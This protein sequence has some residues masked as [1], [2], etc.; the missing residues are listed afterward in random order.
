M[1]N[2]TYICGRNESSNLTSLSKNPKEKLINLARE[3]KQ[4]RFSIVII[5]I[6]LVLHRINPMFQIVH[7]GSI[8]KRV[9]Q[10]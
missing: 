5:A 9:V 8:T 1:N 4:T 6:I 7:Q 2:M 3:L 10:K